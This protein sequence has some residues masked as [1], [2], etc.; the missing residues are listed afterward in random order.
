[1]GHVKGKGLGKHQQGIVA[2]VEAYKLKGRRG[3]GHQTMVDVTASKFDP[4]SEEVSVPEEVSW[5]YNRYRD[6][7]TM[8]QL[9]S[10]KRLGPKKETI[11]DETNFCDEVVLGQVLDSK[12]RLYL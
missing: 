2:P 7:L 11:D 9:K 10:W 1:M 8:E 3:L 6:S 4:S 5:L 12:V